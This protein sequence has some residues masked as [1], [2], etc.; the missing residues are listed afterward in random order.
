M[1]NEK[2]KTYDVPRTLYFSSQRVK[3]S[4]NYLELSRYGKD[5]MIGSPYIRR[6]HDDENEEN[7]KEPEKLTAEEIRK[8]TARRAR[9]TIAD[10]IRCNAWQWHQRNGQAYLPIFITFTFA[11]NIT[12]LT[13]AHKEFTKFIKRLS[14]EHWGQN[15]N[16][17]KY[18]AVVEFQE[19]GAIHYH[20]VFFNL[21]F[22]DRI[23]DK[24]LAIWGNGF[25]WVE[26]V[27]SER[28]IIRYMSKYLTKSIEKGRL[29]SRKSYFVSKGLKKPLVHSFDEV[30]NVV[31]ALTPEEAKFDHFE[32]DHFWLHQVIV[33]SYDLKKYPKIKEQ[34]E[35]KILKK[36]EL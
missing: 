29:P 28:G 23:Y 8:K 9:N 32:Y 10:T 7:K 21:P 6:K 1:E 18:L 12:E 36:Y 31:R 19:R 2:I 22:M 15:V 14:Y 30:V 20:V 3:L 4:G 35:A 34:I 27:K 5:R 24:I 25:T 17:L 11:E 13:L 33:D 26:S 16:T